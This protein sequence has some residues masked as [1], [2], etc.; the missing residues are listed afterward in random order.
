MELA[1]VAVPESVF[2]GRDIADFVRTR[3]EAPEAWTTTIPLVRDGDD[4]RL[5]EALPA[6]RHR[7]YIGRPRAAPMLAAGLS[8]EAAELSIPLP[9]SPQT[10]RVR[11]VDANDRR[12]LAGATVRPHYEFG[13]DT[14]F[15]PGPA[16]TADHRG[17][18]EIPLLE[19]A[20]RG[21]SRQPTWWVETVRHLGRIPLQGVRMADPGRVLEVEVR[22]PATVVGKAW[23]SSGEPAEGRTV[24]WQDKG[25]VARAVVAADGSFRLDSVAV[26]EAGGNTVEVILVEDL[27]AFRMNSAR[28]RVTPGGTSEVEIGEPA[29]R[30]TTAVLFGRVTAGGKP[31][32]G[33]FVMSRTEGAE[34]GQSFVRTGED[35]TFRKED[36]AAG[37]VRYSIF[38]GDPR[39]VDDFWLG[40]LDPV[41][42]PVG[43]EHR[44]D[45]D[46]PGGVFVVKV[47]DA[48]TGAPIPGAVAWGRPEDRQAGKDR[49]PGHR[50]SPG[51]GLRA[52]EDGAARLLAMLPGEPHVIE[53]GIEGY[54]GAKTTGHLPGTAEAPAEV[55]LRLERED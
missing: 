55:T 45:F 42:L 14:V 37:A 7:L 22:P 23:L 53:A 32:A 12:P 21:E 15:L 30:R 34:A 50:Y 13:D 4:L 40:N 43:N 20:V 31:V 44:L 39:A 27:E 8:E 47:V 5:A 52:G 46:L 9:D 25:R 36:V 41:D 1:V 6:G 10:G 28:V 54:R 18:V 29:G 38:L 48:A 2:S 35:G 51:W 16:L 26:R 33:A 49:F 11:L 3:V 24:F 17:E 19:D